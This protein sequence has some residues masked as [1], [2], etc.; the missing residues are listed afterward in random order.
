MS[1]IP[2]YRLT[3][4]INFFQF[5][6]VMALSKFGHCKFVSKIS[7]KLFEVGA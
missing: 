3:S 1:R 4:S 5:S 6:G 7:Q 2:D